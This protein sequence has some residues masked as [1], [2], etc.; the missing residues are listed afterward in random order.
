L[1]K[2]TAAASARRIDDGSLAEAGTEL[3]ILTSAIRERAVGSAKG[4]GDLADR[5]AALETSLGGADNTGRQIEQALATVEASVVRTR[6]TVA[7][8]MMVAPVAPPLAERPQRA[9]RSKRKTVK[10][11]LRPT[12]PQ[13]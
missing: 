9:P 1:D 6:E 13:T 3:T 10:G 7:A 8:M 11:T 2:A 5:L 4:V 12:V